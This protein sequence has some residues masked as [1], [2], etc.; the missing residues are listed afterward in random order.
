MKQLKIY[1][2]A[3]EASPNMDEQIEAMRKNHLDCCLVYRF[4]NRKERY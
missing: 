1:A 2:F 3:D 4:T